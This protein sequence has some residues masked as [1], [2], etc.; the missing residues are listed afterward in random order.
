MRRTLI[1]TLA[2]FLAPVSSQAQVEVGLDWGV[3]VDAGFEFDESITTISLPVP[4]LRL[5]I[6][7]NDQI[8]VETLLRFD[9]ISSDGDSF[10]NFSL[11]PG[12]NVMVGEDGFYLRGEGGF[13]RIAADGDFI[14]GSDDREAFNRFRFLM[15][16]SAAIG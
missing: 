14:D 4:S 6:P 12:V 2:L 15:G 3:T 8:S 16:F 9:R 5:G 10:S 1:L 7:A 13:S 11:I